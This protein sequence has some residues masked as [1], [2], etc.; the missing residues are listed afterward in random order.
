MTRRPRL[1]LVLSALFFGY[2]IFSA[3]G[4]WA[5]AAVAALLALGWLADFF[6]DQL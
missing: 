2:A 6:R 1:A 3:T 4:S 5:F